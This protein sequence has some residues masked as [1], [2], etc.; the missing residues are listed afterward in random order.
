M[1][2]EA[3]DKE[4]E[5]RGPRGCRDAAAAP[6]YGQRKRAGRRVL[7]SLA[8]CL[9][10]RLRL[11]GNRAHRVVDR[12]WQGTVL[13]YTVPNP[14]Q[15]RVTPAPKPGKRAKGRMRQLTHRGRGQHLGGVSAAS[16]RVTRGWGGDLRLARVKAPG[17]PVAPWSC[18]CLRHLLW[19]PWRT[20]KPRGRKPTALGREVARA[21]Q[22]TAPGLGAWWKA[23]A[24]HMHAAGTHG[25][26]AAW[27]LRS[28][29]EQHR[30]MPRST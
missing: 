29:L 4:V 7:A 23:G 3:L 18:R 9:E 11:Q 17:D 2:W 8:R 30:A 22:A 16:N 27:G 24:S 21:R 26:L 1:L 6:V 14:R 10:T 12:P 20:P 19:E 28:L 15:A 13:G 5:R 25:V